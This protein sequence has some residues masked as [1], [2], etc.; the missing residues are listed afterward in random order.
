M[1]SH[2]HHEGQ[3]HHHH[4]HHGHD[5]SDHSAAIPQNVQGDLAAY[6]KAHFDAHAHSYDNTPHIVETNKKWVVPPR[7]PIQHSD[8]FGIHIRRI[9]KAISETIPLSK[10]STT[11]LEYACGT[12][13]VSS[14]LVPYSKS[15]V[16]VDISEGMIQ[17]FR[18]RFE[19]QGLSSDQVKGICQELKGEEGELDGAKFDVVVCSMAYHHFDAQNLQNTTNVL[20]SFLKPAGHLAIIDNE[21]DPEGQ[22][23]YKGVD[24]NR[25]GH[26]T[27][28]SRSHME[29]LFSGAGLSTRSYEH[30]TSFL[31]REATHG[32]FLAVAQKAQ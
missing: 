25:L 15:I 32:V 24:K 22:D 12:G 23:I 29:E 3:G 19:K 13:L 28:F 27:G 31:H 16:G 8:N 7:T 1:S 14:E 20:A 26:S 6:N 21:P 10:D 4:H 9:G 17:Q 30:V 2:A 18:N 5:T 11:V